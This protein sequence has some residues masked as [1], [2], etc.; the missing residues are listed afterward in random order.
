MRALV[1]AFLMAF[2]VTGAQTQHFTAISTVTTNA[3][4]SALSAPDQLPSQLTPS[5]RAGKAV[6]VAVGK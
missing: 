3:I 5:R 4:K 2:V 1:T 6:P